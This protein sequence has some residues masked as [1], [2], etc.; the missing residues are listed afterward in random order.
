MSKVGISAYL[1]AMMDQEA[2]DLHITVG[3]PPQYRIMGQM[4]KVK[5][6][7]LTAADVKE[8]C[9]S[10]LTDAQKGEFEKNLEIDFSFGIKDVSRFRANMFYQRGGMAAVFRRIPF[11]V[12]DFDS[13]K[14]PQVMKNIIHRP[15]G[16]VLVTGPTG[17]GKSTSLAAM[18]DL[19]N[20]EE[21]GHILTIEDP[22]EF[23]HIHKNCVVNQREVGV[24]TKSFSSALRRALRQ[25][26][27]FILV[28]ELRD[29]ETIEMALTMAE[30]GHLVFGT[31]HT[32]GAVQSINRMVNVFPPYQQPQIRQVLSFTLQGILSQNLVSKS[33]EPGRVMAC[34]VMIP[35]VAIRNLIREDK[36][37]QIYSAM[38]VGQEDTGMM[39]LNQH[40]LQH[41]KNGILSKNDALG[42]SHHPDELGKM[43][44]TVPGN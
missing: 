36:L 20:R 3:V 24:D 25:D 39:T 40:L 38:Q 1:R 31:L 16:L 28:G 43:L 13:L 4:V 22:I 42:A 35:N 19:V 33:Y 15:N 32:N 11:Q 23:V 6:D 44:L 5:S 34:E 9:Y 8:L 41:V 2:S 26:P 10:V 7:P 30:T 21:Y 14:I 37:H 12:P 17:S 27:D 18:L 29:I